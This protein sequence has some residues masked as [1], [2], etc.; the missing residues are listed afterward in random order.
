ML[1]SKARQ[2]ASAKTG[3][4][5]FRMQVQLLHRASRIAGRRGSAAVSGRRAGARGA[6]ARCS[7]VRRVPATLDDWAASL[8]WM[9]LKVH[10]GP[11]LT[12]TRPNPNNPI[13]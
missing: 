2:S 6:F 3:L 4:C 9:L 1:A 12:L 13:P 5:F 10:R 7:V 11:L 8:L